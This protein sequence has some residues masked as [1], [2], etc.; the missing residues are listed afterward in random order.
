MKNYAMGDFGD[1]GFFDFDSISKMASTATNFYN[2][3]KST[4]DMAAKFASSLGA[5]K[6]SPK[7]PAPAVGVIAPPPAPS[8]SLNPMA[9]AKSNVLLYSSIAGGVVLVGGLILFLALRKK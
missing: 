4:L 7:R 6:K 3:N 2:S 5:K 9:P 8:Q 1:I